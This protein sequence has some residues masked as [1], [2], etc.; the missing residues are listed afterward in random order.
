MGFGVIG[1]LDSNSRGQLAIGKSPRQGILID[2][3][4]DFE[5]S[6]RQGLPLFRISGGEGFVWVASF[7]QSGRGRLRFFAIDVPTINSL[8]DH[9]GPPATGPSQPADPWKDC[10]SS[11]TE[12]RLKG[13]TVIIEAKGSGSKTRLADALDGRCHSLNE[14]QKYQEAIADCLAAIDA[15]PRYSYAYGNLANAYLRLQE[16]SRSVAASDKAIALKTDFI[17]SR[18]TRAEALEVLGKNADALGDYR[19]ALLID[20]S[21]KRAQEG[22]VRLQRRTSSPPEPC[23]LELPPDGAEN[24]ATNPSSS[25]QFR[26]LD[27]ITKAIDAVT[28]Y[29]S[30]LHSTSHRYSDVSARQ[31]AELEK[32]RAELSNRLTED[33]KLVSDVQKLAEALTEAQSKLADVS[34]ELNRLQQRLEALKHSKKAA[35][36]SRVL[37]QRLDE[38]AS[39]KRQAEQSTTDK[40]ARHANAKES[41]DRQ[42]E[43]DAVQFVNIYYDSLE[44]QQAEQCANQANALAEQVTQKLVDLQLTLKNERR[45][46]QQ[47][48][49]KTLLD[50]LA[51]FAKENADAMSLEIATLTSQLKAAMSADDPDTLARALEKLETR[52][53]TIEAFKQYRADAELRRQLAAA[54][55]LADLRGRAQLVSDFLQLYVRTNITSDAV[56]GMLPIVDNLAAALASGEEGDLK[57]ALDAAEA[58][59]SQAGLKTDYLSFKET[60]GKGSWLPQLPL[61]ERNRFLVEGPTD[62]ILLLVNDT[63]RAHVVRDLRGELIFQDGDAAV[64]FPHRADFDPYAMLQLKSEI[65]SRGARRVLISPAPCAIDSV[66]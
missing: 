66:T 16:Y 12:T 22:L 35:A 4:E 13:C 61:N 47:T 53:T 30:R 31:N 48:N 11:D 28:E 20:P 29:V 1:V 52:L 45:Q 39:A 8:T 27:A 36:A 26:S 46:I 15:N 62:E 43:N 57:H 9:S 42:A 38:V 54:A 24:P 17:W 23:T 33:R 65:Q 58:G 37:T 40:S 63:G 14:L 55:A 3:I 2:Y 49:A 18:L 21:N 64:C 41:A 56:K 60:H 44:A 5:Q 10:Q 6:A 7:D 34:D 19:Y 50:D 59:I 32:R 25:R 51:E